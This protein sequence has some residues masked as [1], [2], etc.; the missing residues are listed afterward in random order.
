MNISWRI[1]TARNALLF[2]QSPIRIWIFTP[3]SLQLSMERYIKFLLQ[4]F[5][6]T[7]G[8]NVVLH[9]AMRENSIRGSVMLREK[10]LFLVFH[11]RNKLLSMISNTGGVIIGIRWVMGKKL[12]SLYRSYINSEVYTNTYRKERWCSEP[13]MRTVRSRTV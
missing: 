12:L 6:L 8:N 5:A 11:L 10:I 1:E 9:F 4:P 7:A 2:F 13:R 3:K